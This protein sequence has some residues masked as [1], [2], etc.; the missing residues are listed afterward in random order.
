MK[1]L[2]DEEVINREFGNLELIKD[3]Y[4]KMVVSLDDM[5]IGNRNG[6][7]HVLAWEL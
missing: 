6:I 1:I 2:T 7:E 3:N 4:P 5:S